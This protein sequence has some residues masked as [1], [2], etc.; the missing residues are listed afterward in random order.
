MPIRLARKSS[1]IVPIATDDE[2]GDL[3]I[4]DPT[5]PQFPSQ[6]NYQEA[7][8]FGSTTNYNQSNSNTPVL[9]GAV[10]SNA[11]SH[12]ESIVRADEKWVNRQ[13]RPAMAWL[14]MTTCA[15]DFI[16]FPV[17]WSLLQA[18]SRGSVTTE[19]QPLTLQGG[20]LYHVAMGAVLGV[21]AYGR[22]KEKINEATLSA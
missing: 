21:A 3:L 17:L 19:W 4:S 1:V 10:P 15:F 20:G 5:I 18:Y 12:T 14:Y 7:S 16:I 13:W 6:I 9:T 2:V 22:T 11:M 8:N